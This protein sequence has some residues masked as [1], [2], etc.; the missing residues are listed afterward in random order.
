MYHSLNDY[1]GQK[2]GGSSS[3]NLMICTMAIFANLEYFGNFCISLVKRRKKKTKLK[4]NSSWY[5]VD[6]IGFSLST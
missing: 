3:T 2:F 6:I 4:T 1:P 5:D